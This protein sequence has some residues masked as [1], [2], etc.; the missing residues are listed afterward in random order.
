MYR[1][2]LCDD[3]YVVIEGLKKILSLDPAIKRSGSCQ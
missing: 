2:V 3:Q 1:V